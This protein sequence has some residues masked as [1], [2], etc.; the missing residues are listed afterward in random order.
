[1]S[2]MW[3]TGLR[4]D[5]SFMPGPIN[6]EGEKDAE[7]LELIGQFTQRMANREGTI[8]IMT[9]HKEHKSV[10]TIRRGDYDPE[11]EDILFEFF[12]QTK[13]DGG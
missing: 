3:K 12:P 1:M 11:F 10:H 9:I 13:T 2:D 5:E 8:Y 6:P 4:L 7:S